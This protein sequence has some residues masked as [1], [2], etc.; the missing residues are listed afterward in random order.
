MKPSRPL[1]L[2][3]RLAAVLPTLLLALGA[4]PVGPRSALASEDTASARDEAKRENVER[5]GKE[6]RRMAQSP[7]AAEKKEEIRKHLEA[8]GSLGGAAAAKAG[9][10]ALAFEDE[11]V[12][13]DVM[14]LVETARDRALV[15]P[16]A[17]L[18]EHKDYRRRFR[19][20]ALVAHA[21]GTIA[22]VS[23]TETLT[24]FVQSEDPHVVAAAATALVSFRTAPRAKRLDPV[25]RMVDRY[26]STYNLKESAR[27]DLRVEQA[28]AEKDW[29]VYGKALRVA[30]QAL[31]GQPNLTHPREFRSWWNDNKK[32]TDW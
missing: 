12:E 4:G 18:V 15:A 19:L 8:L 31:T 25:K 29:E 7:R 24:A 26:E 11:D 16:L 10:E 23:G 9:L 30:L 27:P 3:S 1:P 5:L 17:A 21:L 22:D 32:A 20:H 6:L 28:E 13:K 2:A 14:L